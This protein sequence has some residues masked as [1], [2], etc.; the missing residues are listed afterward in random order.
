[1]TIYDWYMHMYLKP[2]DEIKIIFP[3]G[4]ANDTTKEFR[5]A[6]EQKKK[7][8]SPLWIRMVR[9]RERITVYCFVPFT[10]LYSTMS[11]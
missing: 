1:M 7:I 11:F 6:R 5:I 3:Q 10:R 2:M 4:K 9:Q 8:V